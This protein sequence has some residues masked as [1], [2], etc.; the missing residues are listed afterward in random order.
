MINSLLKEI[1]FD[2]KNKTIEKISRKGKLLSFHLNQE[3]FLL[4]H[5]GMSGAWNISRTPITKKH[6]HLELE[7]RNQNKEKI[8]LG[9]VDPRRF[10]FMYLVDKNQ[11]KKH[12]AKL[13]PD[14][15]DPEFTQS[16]LQE[17]ITKFPERKLKVTLLDQK[18]FAGIGNYLASEICA[19]ARIRPTRLCKKIKE[20]EFP[21]LYNAFFKALN[22]SI[23]NK[24]LTF[25]G[26][27][28]DAFGEKGQGL[29]NLLVFHQEVCQNC[30]KGKVKSLVLAGRNTFYCPLCQK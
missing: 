19:H 14:I 28:Q 25:S 20:S 12:L 10:G 15:Y 5:L 29:Q 23:K 24:G 26:G 11:R 6:T 4:S 13:G 16:F 18:L 22:P 21:K 2:L 30:K 8:Y 17:M 7:T 3:L 1:P 9:Y 27:Y